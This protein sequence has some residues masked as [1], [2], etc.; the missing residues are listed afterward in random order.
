[1]CSPEL[2]TACNEGLVC[3]PLM[4]P[5]GEHVC[6]APFE[7][8]G[9]VVD[10]LDEHPIEGAHVTAMDERGAPM[11]AVTRSG[12][13]GEYVLSLSVARDTAGEPAPAQQWMLAVSARDYLAFPGTLRPSFP[14]D[15]SEAQSPDEAAGA[16]WTIEDPTTVV[17]LIPLGAERPAGVTITGRVE[18]EAAAGTLVVAEGVEPAVVGVADVEGD[19]TLFNVPPGNATVRGYRQGVEL[20]PVALTVAADDIA[21]V[22]LAVITDRIEAMATVEGSVTLVDAGGARTTSV[23][24]VPSSVFAEGFERGPVP[25]GLRAPA[26]P[27]A[28]S[29]TGPFS[30][31]GVPAGVYR[32]LAA[33]ENDQL[34]RD[35]DASISGTQ[36]L[37]IEVAGG[38]A[39]ELGSSFKVTAALEVL[40]P[41][42]DGPEEVEGTPVFR[43]VD[44]SSEDRYEIVVYDA[45]GTEVWRDDQ[46]PRITGGDLVE[47]SYDGAALT[48]GMFYQWRATSWGDGPQGSVALTRTEDLRGVFVVR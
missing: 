18:S 21:D 14:I 9:R 47:V 41:G 2:E 44:D 13:D 12:A 34:V 43:W 5:A 11:T 19:F 35:P 32:V 3:E 36:I 37:E 48:A 42:R 46:L 8:R 16:P 17:A 7:I 20:E 29:I 6:A 15:V 22:R 39:V 45:R 40:G 1:M 4:D 28:P 24:L 31:A 10:A 27:E 26:P 30:I 23:V 33:F 25:L 38:Q